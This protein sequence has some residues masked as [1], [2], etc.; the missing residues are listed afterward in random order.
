M[1]KKRK[2]EQE[3]ETTPEKKSRGFVWNNQ[4]LPAT[5]WPQLRRWVIE[6][7]MVAMCK[8]VNREWRVLFS[9][10]VHERDRRLR[11]D[12]ATHRYFIDGHRD[13]RLISVTTVIHQFFEHFDENKVI[14]AMRESKNWPKSKYYG[15][16]DEQ[17]K[18]LWEENRIAASGN[19]TKMH[20]HL[21]HLFHDRIAGVSSP[22]IEAAKL[23]QLLVE[24]EET[25]RNKEALIE[26]WTEF[27]K[28]EA[29]ASRRLEVE[30]SKIPKP[31]PMAK[32][33]REEAVA[34]L[35]EWYYEYE[36]GPTHDDLEQLWKEHHS[37]VQA[38]DKRFE[39]AKAAQ[40]E[41]LFGPDTFP[42]RE[43]QKFERA[44][45]PILVPEHLRNFLADHPHL[46]PY[47]MEWPLFDKDLLICGTIDALFID[48]DAREGHFG[49]HIEE[50]V[51]CF[52]V[53]TGEHPTI[54][55]VLAMFDWKRSKLINFQGFKNK[56]GKPDT[57]L[58]D[59]DDCNYIH[60]SLQLHIY[61]YLLAKHYGVHV[62]SMHLIVFHPTNKNYLKIE[63]KDMSEVVK[64]I[65]EFRALELSSGTVK[66]ENIVHHEDDDE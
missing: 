50:C 35:K 64:Q 21:E 34:D 49:C 55:L 51:D 48:P 11:F 62:K 3:K 44:Q 4:L 39:K 12:E 6:P 43:Q 29:N 1:A 24:D 58:A 15:L 32:A 60:Y 8:C 7:Q 16:S 52:D 54:N 13:P 26:N 47:R 41:W 37:K 45:Q 42:L 59:E 5:F 61:A 40:C 30:K 20:S 38:W 65:F 33:V 63:C 56:K 28:W 22:E 10:P 66:P 31:P 25:K 57:P 18:M 17:I 2:C 19:G 53:A 14:P 23:E 27:S 9:Q 46:I 36:L